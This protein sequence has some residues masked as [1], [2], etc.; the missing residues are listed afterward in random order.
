MIEKDFNL[1]SIFDTI[2]KINKL[3]E[4]DNPPKHVDYLIVMDDMNYAFDDMKP[5]IKKEFVKLTQNRRNLITNGKSKYDPD[6]RGGVISLIL[7][8]Q[9]FI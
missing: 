2:E 1:R 9:S 3:F 6:Y 7:T 4:Q 8:N 5:A